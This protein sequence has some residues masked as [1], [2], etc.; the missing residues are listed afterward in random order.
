[1]NDRRADGGKQ[2]RV[3]QLGC[4]RTIPQ[5]HSGVG[6]GWEDQATARAQP[7]GGMCRMCH[8]DRFA[9]IR[10]RDVVAGAGDRYVVRW[11]GLKRG[12]TQMMYVFERI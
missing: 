9:R 3:T 8:L 2:Y 7:R 11:Q 4:V 5:V 12:R 6:D 1:M 10:K